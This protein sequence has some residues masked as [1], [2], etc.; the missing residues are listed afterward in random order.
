MGDTAKDPAKLA[1]FFDRA[2]KDPEANITEKS[3]ALITTLAGLLAKQKAAALPKA[4]K[5][6]T[7]QSTSLLDKV[8]GDI[9]RDNTVMLGIARSGREALKNQVLRANDDA[10]NRLAKTMQDGGLG[11]V[12]TKDLAAKREEIKQ[13]IADATVDIALVQARLEFLK[14]LAKMHE[15]ETILPGPGR[16]DAFGS[17]RDM[18]MPVSDIIPTTSPVSYPHLWQVGQTKWLHWDGN[19]NTLLQRNIGQA[20]GLGAVYDPKT[21]TSTVLPRELYIL[22]E[23]TRKLKPPAWPA[24]VLGAIDGEKAARG[25][26]LYATHCL[27]CHTRPDNPDVATRE[28]IYGLKE[29]GTD[30]T[31]VENYAI[32]VSRKPDGSGGTSFAEALRDAANGFTQKAFDD[33]GISAADRLKMDLPPDQIEWRTNPGYIS[34]PLQAPWG[35]S[36]YLHNGSVPTLHDLLQPAAKRPKHF[37]VGYPEYDPVKLGYVSD[38]KLIPADQL[39]KPP[40]MD[41]DTTI[42]GNWN[43]GHEYGTGLSDPEKMDLLEYLKTI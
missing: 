26:A 8:R 37:I 7:D 16:I 34:R 27:Q 22:D 36:P 23:L 6:F 42:K 24:A 19:T 40:L 1:A 35:S 14:K 31:R 12:V 10:F 9:V 25:K 33:N 41:F 39:G 43:A 38:P 28:K 15:S 29:I 18:V 13:G 17:I 5:D 2:Q 21:K 11:Q 4:E 30:P 20:M 32:N 3:R